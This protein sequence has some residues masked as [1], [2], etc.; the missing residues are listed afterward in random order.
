M[1][2]VPRPSLQLTNRVHSFTIQENNKENTHMVEVNIY[3]K[4]L[5]ICLSL[6]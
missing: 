6:F 3:N 1:T 2:V 5:T 4:W